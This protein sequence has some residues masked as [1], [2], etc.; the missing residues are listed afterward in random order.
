MIGETVSHY[1]ILERLGS[2]GMGEVFLA[3][4]LSL[5]LPVALK[6]CE[7]DSEAAARLLREARVASVLN[8]PS[9]AVIYEIGELPLAGGARPFIAMEYV[10][11]ETLA[12]LAKRRPLTVDEILGLVSQVAEALCDAH[13]RGI[14]HRDVKPGNVMVNESD[15]VKVL[16]FGLAKYV[17]LVD[18]AA[19]TWSGRDRAM[20]APGALLGTLAYMSPEQA[21]GREVD[22]RGDVF[23]LGVVLYEL[24]AG[25]QPFGGANAVELID[26]ILHSDPAPIERDA[27]P[28]EAVLERVVRHMLAKAPEARCAS[29]ADVRADLEALRRGAPPSVPEE[30]SAE[31][32]TL[33]VMGFANI[34]QSREDDW[35]GTGIAETVAADLKRIEGLG[36]LSR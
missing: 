13:A 33:A 36:V 6:L 24:L 32:A 31:M 14:V 12:Q 27:A 4:D 30:A 15:S 10:R 28:V 29:M 16:D 18:E 11:G 25:R 22:A 34:T 19:D 8:H 23:S 17:P 5:H 35:L 7:G 1:R 21:R 2:G 26:A 9:I 20:A 3:E